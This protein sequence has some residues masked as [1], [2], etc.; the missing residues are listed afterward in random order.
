VRQPFFSR[1]IAMLLT[2]FFLTGCSEV[3]LASHYAKKFTGY[4]SVGKSQGTYKVGSAYKIKGRKYYPQEDF[5]YKAKGIASWYGPGFHGK[6]TANG[7]TYDQYEL[8]AAH[9]T[10]QMPSFVR[11]TNLENG[12]SVV[13][14]VNDRGPYAYGR[15]IDVSKKAADLLGFRRKGTA[16]VKLEVLEK[17]SRAIASAAKSGRDTTQMAYNNVKAQHYHPQK[18]KIALNANFDPLLYNKP[19]VRQNVGF[20]A[21]DNMAV[22][23]NDAQA[24]PESLQPATIQAQD[25]RVVDV[26][27]VEK[28]QI[29]QVERLVTNMQPSQPAVTQQN[30]DFNFLNELDFLQKAKPEITGHLNKEGRFMPDPVVS[31]RTVKSSD[32][33][34]QAGSFSNRGNAETLRHNL[35]SL[36]N[37][38]VAQIQVKDQTFYRVRLGPILNVSQADTLLADVISKG[39]DTARIVID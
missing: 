24:L 14:R 12:R 4:G 15:I 16:K 35:S 3:Q 22:L 11:V 9:K 2:V 28:S 25:L 5:N 29:Q 10:L 37:A 26:A 30:N 19:A 34:V 36:G 31:K 6:K 1:L 27:S 23:I 33:Y 18:E 7:E 21:S 39:H 38:A 8:T 20:E 17:E 13:V 32:I